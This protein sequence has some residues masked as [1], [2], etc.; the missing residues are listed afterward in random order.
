MHGLPR[1]KRGD[2]IPLKD[3]LVHIVAIDDNGHGERTYYMHCKKSW[4][5]FHADPNDW[6][7]RDAT[8]LA[9]IAACCL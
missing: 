6:V 8:C 9:C 3:G 1:L 5:Q 4:I 2:R 7:P